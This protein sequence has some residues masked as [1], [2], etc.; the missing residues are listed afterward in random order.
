MPELSEKLSSHMKIPP[1]EVISK[2]RKSSLT[3]ED[4]KR[5]KMECKEKEI[6]ETEMKKEKVSFNVALALGHLISSYSIL[7]I[8]SWSSFSL[9]SL[10]S[11]L[12]TPA[13]KSTRQIALAK[14][15]VGS[16][17]ISSFFKKKD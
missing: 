10:I 7:I 13:K 5:I 2:K 17:S 16:K 3:A 1:P 15:A 12:K 14:A 8:P 6:A 4:I 9:L 11:F